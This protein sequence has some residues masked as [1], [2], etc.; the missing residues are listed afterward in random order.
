MTILQITGIVVGWLILGILT[1]VLMYFRRVIG[2]LPTNFEN[3]GKPRVTSFDLFAGKYIALDHKFKPESNNVTGVAIVLLGGI[4]FG[5]WIIGFVFCIIFPFLGFLGMS[6]L[7]GLN[8][9]L[10]GK[11]L[12][13][14]LREYINGKES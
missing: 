10:G 11:K 7:S 6:I 13:A 4:S 2:G 9:L 3:R 5:I 1:Q 12:D 8:R 14:N